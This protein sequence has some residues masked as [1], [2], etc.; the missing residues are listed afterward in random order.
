MKKCICFNNITSLF[1]I[2]S[3]LFI[4][5]PQISQTDKQ[6]QDLENIWYKLGF[7]L[8]YIFT[9]KSLLALLIANLLFWLP[10]DIGDS[11]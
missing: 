7:G 3:I 9:R 4:Q 10:H 1:A 2:T 5:I 6:N 8:R 11:L